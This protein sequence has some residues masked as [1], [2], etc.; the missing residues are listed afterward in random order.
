MVFD[1]SI[2]HGSYSWLKY[3]FYL[4]N[5]VCV[6]LLSAI[7]IFSSQSSNS[8]RFFIIIPSYFERSIRSVV[9]NM[10]IISLLIGSISFLRPKLSSLMFS[11]CIR[12]QLWKEEGERCRRE[13]GRVGQTM[14]EPAKA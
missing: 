1:C 6:F 2:I 13:A 8:G 11:R 10:T 5:I 7:H 12:M 4:P 14:L 9:S 3:T